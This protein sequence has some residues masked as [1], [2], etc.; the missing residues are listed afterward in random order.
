[1][2]QSIIKPNARPNWPARAVGKDIG[3]RADLALSC[4]PARPALTSS[5]G[6]LTIVG[7]TKTFYIQGLHCLGNEALPGRG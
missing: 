5:S 2:L 1:M 4:R 6:L 7:Q 3:D